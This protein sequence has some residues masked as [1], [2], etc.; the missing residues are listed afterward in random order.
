MIYLRVM[1]KLSYRISPGKWAG[2]VMSV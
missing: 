1:M 2:F